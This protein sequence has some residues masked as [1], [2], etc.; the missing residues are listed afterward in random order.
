MKAYIILNNN[1]NTF[2]LNIGYHVK[3]VDFMR[4][5]ERIE[6]IAQ[7]ISKYNIDCLD[8]V[9]KGL[10]DMD[11]GV[12][13][14]NTFK[15]PEQEHLQCIF[16]TLPLDET[17]G[18][19]QI[20]L[21]VPY[22]MNIIEIIK[23]LNG[24]FNFDTQRWILC[25]NVMPE[26]ESNLKSLGHIL[27]EQSSEI[28]FPIPKARSFKAKIKKYYEKGICELEF[29]YRKDICDFVKSIPGRKFDS[30]TSHW[31]FPLNE[32]SKIIDGLSNPKFNCETSTLTDSQFFSRKN[33]KV[34]DLT[35]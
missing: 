32:F 19:P 30:I 18:S 22:R 4:N 25:A 8:K 6:M 5:F 7:N 28:V 21:Y 15:V 2:K 26:L 34:N 31:T 14:V 10:I 1:E 12:D 9:T 17:T 13:I 35:Q 20:Y 29:D 16:A 3:V 27:M 33:V 11:I 24:R 23:Q